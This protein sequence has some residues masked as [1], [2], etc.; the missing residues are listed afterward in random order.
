MSEG[1]SERF[2]PLKPTVGTEANDHADPVDK[3]GLGVLLLLHGE[4]E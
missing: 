2:W 1:A 4:E 3:S